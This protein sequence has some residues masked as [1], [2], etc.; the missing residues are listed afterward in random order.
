MAAATASRSA[1]SSF[2]ICPASQ[3]FLRLR[4]AASSAVPSRV[5]DTV[6][7]RRSAGSSVRSTRPAAVSL[8][9]T[10][11]MLGGA[12]PLVLGQRAERHGAVALDG[13]ER[14]DLAGRQAGVGLP[15]QL[16]AQA[17]DDDSQPRRLRARVE[18]RRGERRGHAREFSST[19]YL[20]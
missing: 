20:R 17:G 11:V 8:A 13:G 18:G 3:A 4:D 16:A 6:V 9:T 12:T 19:N 1:G 7:L 5:S 15:A 10:F 14:R 2:F